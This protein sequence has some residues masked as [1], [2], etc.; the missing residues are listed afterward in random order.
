[1]SSLHGGVPGAALSKP[2]PVRLSVSARLRLC[3][4]G[5]SA[6]SPM[7]FPALDRVDFFAGRPPLS[8]HLPPVLSHSS[9]K[10]QAQPGL[11]S[12]R[13]PDK[14]VSLNE[15]DAGPKPSLSA[16]VPVGTVVFCPTDVCQSLAP[17]TCARLG[18]FLRFLLETSGPV[19]LYT[20][21]RGTP[22]CSHPQ[23]IPSHEAQNLSQNPGRPGRP[24]SL[25]RRRRNDLFAL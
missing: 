23:T 14:I 20:G 21:C 8:R 3:T 17:D 25:W 7:P 18:K 9:P 10:G 15:P 16:E 19:S 22:S 24:C 6:G 12:A 2:L 1:M 11:A 5:S 13:L 4:S